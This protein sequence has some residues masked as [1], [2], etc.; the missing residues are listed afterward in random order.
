M[1][2]RLGKTCGPSGNGGR[3]KV[4][5]SGGLGSSHRALVVV[6]TYSAV[7]L[8]EPG[9]FWRCCFRRGMRAGGFT[10]AF[11]GM[12]GMR[13]GPGQGA[14]AAPGRWHGQPGDLLVV[15][16][17]FGGAVLECP[18]APPGPDASASLAGLPQVQPLHSHPR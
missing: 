4:R 18:T 17:G 8:E 3:N 7:M 16:E 14:G 15:A 6:W 10:K 5:G 9:V 1:R 13:S 12:G 11:A 2:G